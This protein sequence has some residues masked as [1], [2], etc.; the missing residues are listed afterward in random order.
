MHLIVIFKIAYS[1][2]FDYTNLSLNYV[3]R[4]KFAKF[5]RS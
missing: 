3:T 1:L 2:K 5:S 4:Y